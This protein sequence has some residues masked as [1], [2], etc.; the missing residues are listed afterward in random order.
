MARAAPRAACFALSEDFGVLAGGRARPR[1]AGRRRAAAR[2]DDR[3]RPR[4][5]RLHG[6]RDRGADRRRSADRPARRPGRPAGRGGCGW[7][8]RGRSP[9]TRCGCCAWCGLRSSSTWSPR[10]RRCGA[11]A[12]LASALSGVSAERVFVELRRII[13]SPRARGGLRD[14][15]RAGGHRGRAAGAAGAARGRAEPL[16]PPRRLR[17][18]ARGAR[19]DGRADERRVWLD[20]SWTRASVRIARRWTRCWPS[21][22]P[23]S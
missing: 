20:R 21:R 1:L 9:T 4:A 6:Q 17:P 11:P 19:P 18:H 23:T 16:P 7:R 15:G 10:S 14:D 13:A 12:Q 5:A 22:W 8:D 3:G 2:P